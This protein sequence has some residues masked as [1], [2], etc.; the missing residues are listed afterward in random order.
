MIAIIKKTIKICNAELYNGLFFKVLINI[1]VLLFVIGLQFGDI[2]LKVSSNYFITIWISIN[3]YLIFSLFGSKNRAFLLDLSSL[4]NNRKLLL[5]YMIAGVMNIGWGIFIFFHLLLVM[6][7]TFLNALMVTVIQ[8]IFGLSIG[9]VS[10][11]L[12]KKYVGII[13]IIGLAVHNFISYNP[14]IYNGSSHFLS[15]SEQ[16]Y[17]I[18]AP[19]IINIA[20]LISLILLCVFV[21][22]ILAKSYRGFKCVRLIILIVLCVA[23]YTIM[24]LYDFSKYDNH[25]DE[26]YSVVNKGNHIIKYDDI[27]LDRVNVIYSIVSEFERHYQSI[28]SETRYS[29]YI[30][31]KRYLSAISWRIRNIEPKTVVIN[32]EIMHIHVLS[33]SM[34]YFDYPDLLRNFIDEMKNAMVINIKGYNQSK[35]TRHLLEGYSISIMKDISGDLDLEQSHKVENY[36]IK[37]IDDIF[38]YP[39]TQFNFVYRVGLII[40]NKFPSLVGAVYDKTYKQNP[41]SDKEFIELLEENF[42][43]IVRDKEMQ[44]ILS[45]VNKE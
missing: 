5:L 22:D 24:I 27:P 41:Q 34:I 25:I 13:I 43:D 2:T 36:Y 6:K 28:Q 35:Y 19:N 20:S 31:D 38:S 37:E 15:I 18:N 44:T 12:H 42:K 7:A 30:I 32:K 4:S 11:T 39:T 14:L 1:L 16:L 3:A 40:Y 8:Y 29:K 10:G 9:G 21:T 23:S 33:D 26:K 17:A 45:R